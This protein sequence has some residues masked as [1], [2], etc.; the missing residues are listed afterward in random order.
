MISIWSL[1][2][3]IISA[4]GKIS[5][6]LLAIKDL[7]RYE[8]YTGFPEKFSSLINNGFESNFEISFLIKPLL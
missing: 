1:I 2:K 8:K 4:E 3:R 6:N 5:Y 7:F